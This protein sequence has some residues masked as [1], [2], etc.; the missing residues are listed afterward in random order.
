MDT[1][2]FN[3]LGETERNRKANV[4]IIGATTEDPSSTLLKTLLEEYL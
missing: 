4:L 2:T 3:K 1:G